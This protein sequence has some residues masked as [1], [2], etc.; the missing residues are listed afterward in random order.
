MSFRLGTV[1]YLNARPLTAGLSDEHE[2]IESVPAVLAGQLQSGQLDAALVPIVSY[3][4]NW[5][6]T[7]L[8]PDVCIGADGPVLTVRLL[9]DRPLET[10]ARVAP[11]PNS[12]TSNILLRLLLETHV[13]ITPHYVDRPAQA[14]SRE[15]LLAQADA[16][17]VIGDPAFTSSESPGTD[18]AEAWKEWTGLPFVF[19]A[20]VVHERAVE[21]VDELKDAL[22][23]GADVALDDLIHT[24][25]EAP[26]SVVRKYLTEHLRYDFD[27]AAR[28]GLRLFW[29][30]AAEADL[31]PPAQELRFLR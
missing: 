7:W 11:D 6:S 12:R 2:V 8:F 26:A 16:A 20:W 24:A 30:R 10:V 3:F 17:L 15:E 31:V 25:N 29:E 4:E 27:D 18:L 1:P 5:N 19:A 9:H 22:R 28:E 13:G 23:R 21:R 14:G